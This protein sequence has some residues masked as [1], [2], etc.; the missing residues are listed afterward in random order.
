[1][2]KI[3]ITDRTI[4]QATASPNYSLSFKEKIEVCKLLDK[5]NV[6]LIELDEIKNPKV[7]SLLIK[8]VVTAVTNGIVAVP[9]TLGSDGSNVAAVLTEA[10]S[11]RLQVAAPVSS[12]CMEYIYH[13]KPAAMKEIVVSTV[14][15]CKAHTK[16]IEFIAGDA[17]RSDSAFLYDIVKSVIE[18]G[19]TTVTICDD[20]GAMLPDQFGAFI[21]DIKNNVPELADINLAVCCSNDIAMAD[22]CAVAAIQN[23]ATEV[24]TVAGKLGISDF[25]N[26]VKVIASKGDSFDAITTASNVNIKK[27]VNQIDNIL[28]GKA[29]TELVIEAGA[30]DEVILNAYD[31]KAEVIKAVE[32]LGYE[33]SEEDADNVFEAFRSIASKKENVSSRELDSVV[34]TVAHQ[35]PAKYKL[36]SYTVNSGSDVTSMVHV[37]LGTGEDT[38][39]DIALGDGPVGAAFAAIEKITGRKIE[40]DSLNIRAVTQGSGATGET[41]VKLLHNGKS[42]SGKGIST[43]IVGS[44]IY[45]YISALNKL[46]YEEEEA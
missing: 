42:Y 23:G 5:L 11:Y 2:N 4:V 9:V 25:S 40:L 8:S 36:V 12:V 3:K 1:M 26:I 30:K 44:A 39:E 33:L 20:A 16:D 6:D 22:A 35:V 7:D 46:V 10:E 45:A 43:D 15:A 31:S 13:K 19:A 38:L 14:A 32:K 29:S 34:A 41:V 37:K 27:T 24:K 21:R 18:A 17:T 28:N